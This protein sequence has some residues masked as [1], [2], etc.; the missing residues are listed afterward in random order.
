MPVYPR[1]CVFG[2]IYDVPG[3]AKTTLGR[4]FRLRKVQKSTGDSRRER[5]FDNLVLGTA[6]RVPP[7]MIWVPFRMDLKPNLVPNAGLATFIRQPNAVFR[8][9]FP[10]LIITCLFSIMP[11]ND[12]QFR[13]I[14]SGT[15]S[16]RRSSS[17]AALYPTYI[18]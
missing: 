12:G 2:A 14:S 5:S 17:V 13:K 4:Q 16:Q 7:R 11:K 10:L 15:W 6:A 18:S 1:K 3:V 9:L 8:L